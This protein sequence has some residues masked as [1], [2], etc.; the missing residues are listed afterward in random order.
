M[1]K[2]INFLSIFRS[3]AGIFIFCFLFLGTKYYVYAFLVFIVAS[4]TD[5]FDGYLA[6]KYKLTSIEG[7]IIDPVA[8]KML[9]TFVLIAISV[10]LSSYFVGFMSTI[11][12]SRE[13]FVGA[14]RDFNSRNNNAEATKVSFLAKIKTFFQMS[15]I[16]LYLIG[17][18]INDMLLLI[19]ADIL[20]FIA[21]LIT[22]KTGLDYYKNTFK[23]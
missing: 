5:Y 10:T 19:F 2:F 13:I 20:L 17:L 4:I 14:L 11:I 9:I 12:I 23:K 7:E 1:L 18:M 21:A 3:V 16:S 15:V 8:D 22:I 6:R